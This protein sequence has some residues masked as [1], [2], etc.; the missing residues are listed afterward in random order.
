VRLLLGSL[1]A[2]T[3]AAA[4]GLGTTWLAATRG[5]AFGA[6]SIGAWTAW[7]R[8]GTSEVDPYARATIARTGQLPVGSGDGVAFYAHDDDGGQPLD[9][10]CDT[11]ISG[12]TPQARFWTITIYDAEGRLIPNAINRHG[13]TSQELVRNPD[14]SFEITVAPRV[15]TGNWLPTGGI[16]R[17]LVIMRL[18]DTPVG[19]STRASREVPMPEIARRTCP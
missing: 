4:L 16:D 8:T 13:F 9:G 7:P 5:L 10:R 12:T 2:F 3:I 11:V 17:Y 19:V 18:Y 14:G 1:L 15:R 6:V